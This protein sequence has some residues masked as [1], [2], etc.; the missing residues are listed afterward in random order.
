MCQRM[1]KIL[2]QEFLIPKEI[3]AEAPL[4]SKSGGLGI[5][6]DGAEHISERI[7]SLLPPK[8]LWLWALFVFFSI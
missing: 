3:A 1:G 4:H 2:S 5:D 7:S 8:E 6:Q